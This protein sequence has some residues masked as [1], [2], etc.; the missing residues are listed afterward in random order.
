MRGTSGPVDANGNYNFYCRTCGKVQLL[1]DIPTICI[2]CGNELIDDGFGISGDNGL[3]ETSSTAYS[4]RGE[5]IV[6]VD[7]KIR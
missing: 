4:G 6:D 7:K 2:W 5:V 3:S 1:K